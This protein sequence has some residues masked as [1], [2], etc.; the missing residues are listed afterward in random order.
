MTGLRSRIPAKRTLIS[1]F[2]GWAGPPA[3]PYRRVAG[4]TRELRI[5][6]RKMARCSTRS[7]CRQSRQIVDSLGEHSTHRGRWLIHPQQGGQGGR[8]VDW[9]HP[10]VIDAG[11]EGR[12]IK[13]QR[14]MAVIGPGAEMGGAALQRLHLVGSRNH[15]D[16]PAAI[17]AVAVRQQ[18]SPLR[19]RQLSRG[20]LLAGV[21]VHHDGGGRQANRGRR[22]RG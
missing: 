1:G 3:G 6:T 8:Q 15:H 21:G 2:T 7:R 13:R 12:S 10:A 9:L 18:Q 5:V 14:D 16:V 4:A 11:S 20:Q 17:G 22:R 19:R